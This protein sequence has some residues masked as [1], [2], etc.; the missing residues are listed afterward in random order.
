MLFKNDSINPRNSEFVFL[1]GNAS[2]RYPNSRYLSV[3]F[4]NRSH[5]AITIMLNF[6]YGLGIIERENI[7]IYAINGSDRKLITSPTRTKNATDLIYQ[8]EAFIDPNQ[9][10]GTDVIYDRLNKPLDKFD[11]LHGIVVARSFLRALNQSEEYSKTKNEQFESEGNLKQK[12]NI[13]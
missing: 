11:Q 8:G 10:D 3:N 7:K 5:N 2:W 9:K 12:W 1:E 4:F 13:S 6:E